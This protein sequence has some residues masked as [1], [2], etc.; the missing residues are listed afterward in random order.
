MSHVLVL[1]GGFGGLVAAERLAKRLAPEHRVTL[2]SRGERFLFYPA[3]VKL[4]FGSCEPGDV[5]FDMR[6]TLTDRRV[7]FVQAEVARIEPEERH[8]IT[9]GGEVEGRIHYDY[10]VL[11]LGRR[12]ATEQ[13]PGFYEHAHH[14][15]S[16]ESALE[17]G[18]AVRGFKEGHA[19]LGYCPGAR[20]AIPVYE[21]A[22]ALARRL[23]EEGRRGQARITIITPEPP[24]SPMEGEEIRGALRDALDAHNVA[25]WPDFPVNKVTADRVHTR[26]GAGLHYDLLM[27]VP[28]FQGPGALIGTG[29]TDEEGYVRV[30]SR[31]RVRGVE[32]MY[33][34]GDC[35]NLPGPKMG[36]MAVNQAEVAA[37]NLAAEI[38]GAEPS[39]VYNHEM[40]L[41][42]DEGGHSSIY[43]SK[44]LGNG[45]GATVRQGRFWGWAKWVH[46]KYWESLHG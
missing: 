42:I 17:F 33:A 22:L 15:L 39:A 31:M 24:G 18:D 30:D 38:D 28:P 13:V 4:A 40:K 21:A 26:D 36:H 14:L 3:F 12:L 43:F 41:V 45:H 7:R 32:R 16:V 35:V 6:E 25:F 34:V 37:A 1:G 8:V 29:L 27:L 44:E 9:S 46:E 23:E 19:V 5:S 10:L 2:V 11:A 20:L